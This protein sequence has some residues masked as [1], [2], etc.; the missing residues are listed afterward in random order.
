MHH[1]HNRQ[2]G[3]QGRRMTSRI[4]V[5]ERK[6]MHASQSQLAGRGSGEI[7]TPRITIIERKETQKEKDRT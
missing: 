5:I 2:G 4:T 1:S 6:E 3:G 7:H